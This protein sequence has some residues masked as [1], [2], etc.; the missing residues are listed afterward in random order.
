MYL[1]L[2]SLICA[3][4]SVGSTLTDVVLGIN[5]GNKEPWNSWS[6]FKITSLLFLICGAGIW[7]LPL[8]FFCITCFILEALFDDLYKRISLP[9]SNLVEIA[10][11][12]REHQNLCQVVEMANNML[13][14][15][16]LE[17]VTFLIPVTCF[18]FYQVANVNLRQ[19]GAS[20]FL[21]FNLYWL[22]T[23]SAFLAV[24]L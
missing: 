18:N 19:E 10:T 21:I 13:S 5:M 15:L 14:P 12:R 4:T 8:L 9:F 16:L 17:V 11:L 24:I 3:F 6:G 2:F 1:I 22:L 20:V 7:I 23:S